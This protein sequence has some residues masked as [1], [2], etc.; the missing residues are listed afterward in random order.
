VIRDLRAGTIDVQTAVSR[1]ID[2]T[3]ERAAALRPAA[4][5]ELE[6]VL[7]HA[8]ADDPALVELVKELARGR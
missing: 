5:A 7:R 3:L 6:K 1:L 4:R 2:H 8:V